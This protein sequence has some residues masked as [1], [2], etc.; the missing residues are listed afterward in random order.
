MICHDIKRGRLGLRLW[1]GMVGGS[2]ERT[3]LWW[4]TELGIGWYDAGTAL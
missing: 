1:F 3:R 4:S 2:S